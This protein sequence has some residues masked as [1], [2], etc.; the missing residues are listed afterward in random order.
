MNITEYLTKNPNTGRRK[1]SKLFKIPESQA[2]K[3]V[4]NFK[5]NELLDIDHSELLDHAVD[6]ELKNQNLRDTQRIERQIR[7]EY[8]ETNQIQILTKELIECVK[9]N[10]APITIKHEEMENE[11]YTGIVHLSDF[12][13]NELVDLQHNKYN[14]KVAAQRLQKF[15]NKLKKIFK[16]NGISNVLIFMTGDMFSAMKHPDQMISMAT[17][18]GQ[19]VFVGA[20]IIQQ[21][22][23]DLNE[24]FNVSVGCV[25]GNETR[26]TSFINIPSG[27]MLMSD[28]LDITL[29]SVLKLMFKGT[30]INFLETNVIDCVVNI[31]GNNFLFTHGH[32]FSHSNLQKS[33]SELKGKFQSRNIHI[34]YV[35][36]GHV[37]NSWVSSDGFFRSGSLVGDNDYSYNKLNYCGRASQ[38]VYMVSKK[39]IEG[40]CIDLQFYDGYDGYVVD[41]QL[42]HNQKI[43]HEVK[44][45]NVIKF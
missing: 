11:E 44:N 7:K 22:I 45:V 41:K 12:H 31:H 2:R 18:R 17:S 39:S 36:F 16:C 34:D 35:C 40:V 3:I 5:Q 23:L 8:R 29:F 6:L 21:F 24:D 19:A 14:F 28:N 13:L 1:L 30:N 38:N 15:S 25:A 20:S 43:E 10:P 9:T 32:T 37:H 4:K 27:T 33:I 26:E 42:L